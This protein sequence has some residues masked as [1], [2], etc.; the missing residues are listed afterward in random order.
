MAPMALLTLPTEMLRD[1]DQHPHPASPH[2][3][4][5]ERVY[6]L[7][8]MLLLFGAPLGMMLAR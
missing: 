8:L 2:G 5:R 6:A 3:E 7:A 4:R 1:A